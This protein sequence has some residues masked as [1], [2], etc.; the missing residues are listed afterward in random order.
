MKKNR[1][2][3]LSDNLKKGYLK[4]VLKAKDVIQFLISTGFESNRDPE[5]SALENLSFEGS[6]ITKAEVNQNYI[7]IHFKK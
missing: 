6:F 3:E 5:F 1:K 2:I 7:I 4:G